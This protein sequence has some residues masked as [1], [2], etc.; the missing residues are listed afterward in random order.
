[1]DE[2]EFHRN[3]LVQ[4][5]VLRRL[6]VIGEAARQLPQQIKD[7]HSGVPW[8]D[9]VAMRN[10]LTHEYFG[11]LLDRVWNVVRKDLPDLRSKIEAVRRAVG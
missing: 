8:A 4:D 2:K 5:A 7:S 9:I 6:E 1:M 3:R 11:V 10:R